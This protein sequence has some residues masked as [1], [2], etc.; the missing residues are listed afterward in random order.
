MTSMWTKQRKPCAVYDKEEPP[1]KSDIDDSDTEAAAP[2]SAASKK[3][4][5]KI[6]QKKG[7]KKSRRKRQ[8]RK[9]DPRPARSCGS[10]RALFK[11]KVAAD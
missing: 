3:N 5:K 1:T 8:R 11:I 2:K 6:N 7:A 10:D 4:K 9:S